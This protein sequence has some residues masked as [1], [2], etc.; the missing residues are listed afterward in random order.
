M[1]KTKRKYF[2]ICHFNVVCRGW[3]VVIFMTLYVNNPNNVC[4]GFTE[5]KIKWKKITRR[6]LQ[7]PLVIFD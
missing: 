6:E 1:L 7:T 3:D 2:A 4:G 5:A